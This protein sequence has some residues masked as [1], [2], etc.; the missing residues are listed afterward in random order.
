MPAVSESF[1]VMLRFFTRC[2]KMLELQSVFS[3]PRSMDLLLKDLPRLASFR[4]DPIFTGDDP[5]S[6]I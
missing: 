2:E 4:L 3:R 5:Q 1:C 6:L